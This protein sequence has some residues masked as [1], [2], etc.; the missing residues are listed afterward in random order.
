MDTSL[1]A[2]YATRLKSIKKNFPT[3]LLVR[4]Y[5]SNSITFV[6]FYVHHV[7]RVKRR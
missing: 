5:V 7:K 4:M 3:N 1:V 2:A 6:H